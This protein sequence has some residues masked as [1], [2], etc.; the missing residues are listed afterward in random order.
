MECSQHLVPGDWKPGSQAAAFNIRTY[1]QSYGTAVVDPVD[2]WTRRS[3]G[4]PWMTGERIRASDKYISSLLG[5]TF[6][7]WPGQERL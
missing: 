3:G 5:G 2:L 7:L 1:V 4:V 6:K